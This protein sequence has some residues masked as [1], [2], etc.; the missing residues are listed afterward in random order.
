MTDAGQ[1]DTREILDGVRGWVE[2]ESPT[3]DAVNRMVIPRCTV[4][5]GAMRPPFEKLPATVAL[6][7]QARELAAGIGFELE[8][9]TAGGASDGNFTAPMTPTLDGL[10]VMGK[11][12]HTDF[13]QIEVPS[14]EPRAKLFFRLLETLS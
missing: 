6:F 2:I 8:D 14:L 1:F 7:E 13:E 4:D 10:G 3:N 11:G 9:H 5:G 12:A